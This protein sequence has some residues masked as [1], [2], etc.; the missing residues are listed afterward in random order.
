MIKQHNHKP[1]DEHDEY[2]WKYIKKGKYNN[3]N[4]KRENDLKSKVKEK[5]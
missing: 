1:S 5:D 4:N 3:N 2:M